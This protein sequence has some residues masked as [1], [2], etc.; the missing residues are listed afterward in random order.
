MQKHNDCWK[1]ILNSSDGYEPYHDLRWHD[2]DSCLREVRARAM[3]RGFEDKLKFR[4]TQFSTET[5]SVIAFWDGWIT[6]EGVLL[7]IA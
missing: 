6:H 7:D 4:L 2:L 3:Q 5:H 1:F